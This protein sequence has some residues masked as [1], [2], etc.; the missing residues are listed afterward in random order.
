MPTT[1]QEQVRQSGLVPLDEEWNQNG[2]PPLEGGY[3][4][5]HA[6]V[7]LDHPENDDNNNNNKG[8]TVVVL[9]GY[10]EDGNVTHSVLVLNLAEPDKQWREGPPMNKRRRAHA[11]VVCNG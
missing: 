2:W 9:G 6:S 11:A 4:Y 1:W 5:D 10:D 8:Q 3:R 7:A